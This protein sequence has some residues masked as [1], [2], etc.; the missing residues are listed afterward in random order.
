MLRCPSVVDIAGLSY[1][2]SGFNKSI[3]QPPSSNQ[4]RSLFTPFYNLLNPNLN[5]TSSNLLKLTAH[6]PVVISET[7]APYYYHLPTSS[8][9]YDQVGDTDLTGPLPNT[10]DFTPA[11]ASPPYSNSD[12]ELYIKAT[13]F[14]QLTS[15]VTSAMFPNLL[16]VSLFNYFKRGELPVLADF[17]SVGGNATVEQW[18]RNSIGNQTAYDLGYTGAGSKMGSGWLGLAFT[19]LTGVVLTAL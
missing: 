12:D 10:S 4:F 19:C 3:N 16:A 8:P 7:S 5:S 18:F 1:Y 13:W 6:I 9:Y 2:S 15:N 17:R 14:V 11:L